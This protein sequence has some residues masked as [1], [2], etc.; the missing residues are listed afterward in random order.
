[1][2]LSEG[3]GLLSQAAAPFR[4]PLQLSPA[5]LRRKNV[6]IEFF[7]RFLKSLLMHALRR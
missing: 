2:T 3:G 7:P 4:Y 5:V 6:K 1:V